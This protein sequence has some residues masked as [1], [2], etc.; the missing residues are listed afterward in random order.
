LTPP[1]TNDI[2]AVPAKRGLVTKRETDTREKRERER[3]RVV[4]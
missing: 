2:K 1:L 4:D 3:E